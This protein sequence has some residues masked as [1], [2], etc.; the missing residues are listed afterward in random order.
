VAGLC[1]AVT[2]PLNPTASGRLPRRAALSRLGSLLLGALP[3]GALGWWGAIGVRAAVDRG[4]GP[5][6]LFVA[7]LDAIGWGQSLVYQTP[8]GSEIAITRRGRGSSPDDFVALSNV[9]P[10]M[11]CR[12]RWDRGAQHYVCPCHDGTFDAGG[13]PTGGPP[14]REGTPL[15]GFALEVARDLLFVLLPAAEIE[16]RP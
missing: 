11:G 13:R 1:F 15:G 4:P 12:V 16:A 9:C 14:L 8:A 3:L 7:P 6:R 10:H 5:R 2:V